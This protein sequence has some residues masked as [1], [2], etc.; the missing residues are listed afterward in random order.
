MVVIGLKRADEVAVGDV[1]RTERGVRETGML[2]TWCQVIGVEPMS[3]G[4]S[5]KLTVVRPRSV[6]GV[7]ALGNVTTVGR[8]VC[9]FDLM[10]V[11][12]T[13]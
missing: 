8:T 3:D 7:I 2:A 1:V 10:D 4:L 6:D 13:V 11:Q 12:I 5:V 9:R